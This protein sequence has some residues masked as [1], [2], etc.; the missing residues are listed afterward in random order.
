MQIIMHILKLWAEE[1]RKET[2]EVVNVTTISREHNG[3]QETGYNFS[4]KNDTNTDNGDLKIYS[5]MFV[6]SL[7]LLS[8]ELNFNENVKNYWV[9]LINCIINMLFIISWVYMIIQSVL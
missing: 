4:F 1:L 7:L 6:H 2:T 5:D 3:E 9:I 8:F